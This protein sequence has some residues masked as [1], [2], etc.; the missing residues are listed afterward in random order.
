MSCYIDTAGRCMGQGMCHAAAVTD[1]VETFVAAFQMLIQF[2]F[3]IVEFYFY[4]VEQGVIICSTRCD[5][6]QSIDH[7][8]DAVQD[9]FWKYQT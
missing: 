9:T 7:F 4:A 5:F 3:H 1:D 2:Y 6:V 8:H